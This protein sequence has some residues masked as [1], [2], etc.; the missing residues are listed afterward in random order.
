M[1]IIR[2]RNEN[3][4][5]LGG[6]MEIAISKNRASLWRKNRASQCCFLNT[7]KK[8]VIKKT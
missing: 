6:G 5:H 8:Y 4:S 7:H 2:I 1:R 3:H